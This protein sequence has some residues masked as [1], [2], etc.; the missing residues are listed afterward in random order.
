[1]KKDKKKSIYA[2]IVLSLLSLMSISCNNLYKNDLINDGNKKNSEQKICIEDPQIILGEKIENPFSL[3]S[4]MHHEMQQEGK[5][6]KQMHIILKH[7]LQMQ[8]N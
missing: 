3:K 1:M 5:L 2:L 6:L 4:L 8:Q 7:I